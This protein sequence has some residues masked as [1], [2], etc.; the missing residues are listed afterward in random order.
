MTTQ[1]GY[2]FHMPVDGATRRYTIAPIFSPE[3]NLQQ[4]AISQDA[5][6]DKRQT[7]H[8]AMDPAVFKQAALPGVEVLSRIAIGQAT[9]DKLFGGPGESEEILDFTIEPWQG[10]LRPLNS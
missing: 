7:I 10:D 3:G 4:L 1:A 9:Q 2:E 8:I 5:P 6:P